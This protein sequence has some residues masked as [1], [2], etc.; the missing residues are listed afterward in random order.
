MPFEGVETISP[1]PPVWREPGV[2]LDQRL[3]T[4]LVPPPLGIPAD[5][6]QTGLAQHPQM[7]GRAGLGQP[8]PV[9]ELANHT[10]A[11]QQQIQDPPPGRLGKHVERR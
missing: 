1:Q 9:G 6:H 11:L 2:D 8:E 10:R 4:Q 5:P 3:G 7:L